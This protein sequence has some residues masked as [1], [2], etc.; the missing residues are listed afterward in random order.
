MDLYRLLENFGLPVMILAVITWGARNSATV[1][2]RDLVIPFRDKGLIRVELFIDKLDMALDKTLERHQETMHASERH[3]D[4]SYRIL[5]EIQDMRQRCERIAEA[6]DLSEAPTTQARRPRRRRNSQTKP[7]TPPPP[8]GGA[9]G[10][11]GT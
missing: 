9:G 7:I 1:V 4:V 10:A 6:M 8:P 5:E 3:E 11:S 2:W